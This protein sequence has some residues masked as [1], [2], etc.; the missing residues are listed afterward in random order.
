MEVTGADA[1]EGVDGGV[2]EVDDGGFAVVELFGD[3]EDAEGFEEFAGVVLA[4]G[5][6]VGEE[7]VVAVVEAAVGF[8]GGDGESRADGAGGAQGLVGA[9]G[10]LSA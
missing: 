6:G 4:V 5:A 2:E 9:A 10:E 7:G 8:G 3:V 1:A